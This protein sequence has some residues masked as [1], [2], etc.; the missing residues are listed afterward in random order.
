MQ[1]S[2]PPPLPAASNDQVPALPP[3]V[4]NADATNDEPQTFDFMTLDNV[5]QLLIIEYLPI[6]TICDLPLV[7]KHMRDIIYTHDEAILRTLLSREM[8]RLT[9]AI[10]SFDYN[11]LPFLTA[12]SHWTHH[13][14][15]WLTD[16]TNGSWSF[17]G[18]CVMDTPANADRRQMLKVGVEWYTE[19]QGLDPT[20]PNQI[21]NL[22]LYAVY[23]N[24]LHLSIHRP[25]EATLIQDYELHITAPNDYIEVL[26]K[27]SKRREPATSNVDQSIESCV[28]KVKS[29]ETWLSANIYGSYYHVGRSPDGDMNVERAADLPHLHRYLTNLETVPGVPHNH[30]LGQFF[31]VA[32][33]PT[34]RIAYCARDQWTESTVR[35]HLDPFGGGPVPLRVRV[36]VLENIYIY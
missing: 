7:C 8:S 10:Q 28:E 6:T 35:A 27:I 29:D 19:C 33:L 15:I 31:G 3:Q 9:R 4:N 13:K 21:G 26:R 25:F 1:Q 2:D 34:I 5:L 12:L 16:V 23:L 30:L 36:R 24:K 18:K 32:N 17:A 22:P 14:G 20:D 11:G